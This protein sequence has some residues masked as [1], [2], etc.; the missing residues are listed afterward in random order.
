MLCFAATCLDFAAVLDTNNISPHFPMYNHL[1]PFK[2][3][4]QSVTTTTMYT[5]CIYKTQ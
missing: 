5:I 3:L 1:I 2:H 4:K